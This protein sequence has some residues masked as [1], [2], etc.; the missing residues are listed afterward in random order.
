MSV[1]RDEFARLV[2]EQ[3][4]SYGEARP[5]THDAPRDRLVV[6]EPPGPMHFV[7][8]G[9]AYQ[10][11]LSAPEG[12]RR[13]VLSGRV[14]SVPPRPSSFEQ[15]RLFRHVLPRVRDRAW[16]SALRRQAELELGADE[17]A[18][19][20]LMLPFKELNSQLAAHLAFELPT[21]VMEI[22]RERLTSWSADFEKL[23]RR[24]LD[25]LRERTPR[26]FLNPEPGVF[27]SP[28]HDGLDASRMLL[29]ERIEALPVK[30]TPVAM[31][32][33][34][35]VLLVTGDQDDEGLGVVAAWAEEAINE[36]RVNSAL[37]F[38]LE[39]GAWTPW[40]P[41]RP[42]PAWQKLKL[43]QLQT[44]ASIVARQKEVLE[45]LLE[46]NGHPIAVPS[47]RAFR[48]LSGDIVTSAAWTE[49]QEALLPEADRVEF[50]RLS[51]DGNPKNA[52]GWSVK[53]DVAKKTM[54]EQMQP[55]GDVPERY[56]VNSFPEEGA[57]LAME[58]ESKD[59]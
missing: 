43:L 53:W 59:A 44:L 57:L 3:L 16:F 32:P 56:R 30:G 23:Y 25:N 12:L 38:R 55:T 8:L 20:E 13:R 24:A 6:G 50:L 52:K 34:H 10:D 39:K 46:A 4:R 35:D 27:V 14:W 28:Y 18:I 7:S 19:E 51:P 2:E 54:G 49:G 15:E 5:V 21:S 29:V 48:T 47:F 9:N 36:P 17:K 11:Y 33:T 58:A 42:H 41:P 31:A 37:C 40:L 22:G 26:D 1:S 45:A